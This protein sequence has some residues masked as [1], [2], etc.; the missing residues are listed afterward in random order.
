MCRLALFFVF[1]LC[2]FFLLKSQIKLKGT[3]IDAS[4]SS[5]IE[6]VNIGFPKKGVGTVS[7]EK[8]EFV[9][10]VPDS[11]KSDS[12]VFSHISYK[13]K[14]IKLEENLSVITLTEAKK[15]LSEVIILPNKIKSKWIN[16]GISIPVSSMLSNL[17]EEVGIPLDFKKEALLRQVKVKVKSCSYDSVIVRV[18]L[19]NLKEGIVGDLIS[20]EPLYTTIFKNKKSQ[21]YILDFV[22]SIK[23]SDGSILLSMECV[24]YHGE[25]DSKIVFPTNAGTGYSRSISLGDFEKIPFNTG[26]SLKATY[27]K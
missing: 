12:I 5:P 9:L 23:I 10:I 27:L 7:S 2:P 11:L 18:N 21:E 13:T 15:D 19:Y 8:G 4:S 6:F 3:V 14:K 22:E 1:I 25:V 24:A 20:T 26:L 17:G 16:K